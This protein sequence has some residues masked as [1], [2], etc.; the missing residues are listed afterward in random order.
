MAGRCRCGKPPW[1][2]LD[3]PVEVQDQMFSAFYTPQFSSDG[4]LIY[5]QIQYGAVS[6]AVLRLA[7]GGGR[8]VFV[9]DALAFALIPSGKYKDDLIV[10][11]YRHL[12]AQGYYDWFYLM[13]PGANELGVIGQNQDEVY[14]FVSTF[15]G[16]V[17][18]AS[19]PSWDSADLGW[20]PCINAIR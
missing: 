18:P 6:G 19:C 2:L 8:P 1:L 9:T 17:G 7:I 3:S 16:D 13:S 11:L 4:K 5:F 12:L 15:A 20:M 14:N 10:Y